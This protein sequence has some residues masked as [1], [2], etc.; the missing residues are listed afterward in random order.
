M[1]NDEKIVEKIEALRKVKMPEDEIQSL[2]ELK[3]QP[4][5]VIDQYNQQKD[6]KTA[7]ETAELLQEGIKKKGT[8][9]YHKVLRLVR[10]GVLKPIEDKSSNK[11]GYRFHIDE[12]N[13]FIDESNMTSDDWKS[14]VARL[15]KELEKLRQENERLKKRNKGLNDKN[16][17]LEEKAKVTDK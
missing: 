1:K 12:I 16:K 2:L 5:A 6:H 17:K 4:Q 15:E 9:N 8:Y 13:R 11:D 10:D 3:Q 7:V 14:K